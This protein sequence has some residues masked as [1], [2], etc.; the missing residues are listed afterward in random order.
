MGLRDA[1]GRSRWRRLRFGF[2]TRK[3]QPFGPFPGMHGRRTCFSLSRDEARPSDPS[4]SVDVFSVITIDHERKVSGLYEY[5]ARNRPR[6]TTVPILKRMYLRKRVMKP[7]GFDLRLDASGQV[8]PV[9]LDEPVHLGTTCSGGQYPWIDPSGR[10]GLF[11]SRLYAPFSRGGIERSAKFVENDHR[12]LITKQ[13][14]MKLFDVTDAQRTFTGHKRKQ[15][16]EDIGM[17]PNNS[18]H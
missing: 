15:A 6:H 8:P 13:R 14:R 10:V 7:R 18:G 9:K 16:I 4:G 17:S 1:G 3:D 5:N 12:V 2:D 11:G